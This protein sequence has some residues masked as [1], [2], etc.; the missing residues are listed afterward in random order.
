MQS[1]ALG[2]KNEGV[3]SVDNPFA[4]WRWLAVW[5]TLRGAIETN[6][7]AFHFVLSQGVMQAV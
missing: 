7:T 1:A 5:P 6:E 3:E 2:V 4:L